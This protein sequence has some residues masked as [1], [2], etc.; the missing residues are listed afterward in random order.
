MESS[1]SKTGR[2][3]TEDVVVLSENGVGQFG[4]PDLPRPKR[5]GS[6]HGR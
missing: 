3:L 6:L 1:K 5:H 2:F 4:I